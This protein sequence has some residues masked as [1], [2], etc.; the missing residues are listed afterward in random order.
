VISHRKDVP[1]SGSIQGVYYAFKRVF[2]DNDRNYGSLVLISTEKR[3][4]IM[5]CILRASGKNFDVDKFLSQT[6]L[7]P[8]AVF[9][10]GKPK[11]QARPKGKKNEFSGINIEVS[12]ADFNQLDQ[13]IQDAIKFLQK[14]KDEVRNLIDFLGLDSESEIDFAI[15][16]RNVRAQTDYFPP[17]LLVLAGT[18]GL[19]IRLSIYPCDEGR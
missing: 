11:Y 1:G 8:C 6:K 15:E 12:N 17:K 7:Q 18:L 14:N 5:S 10:K 2:W 13:Q 19:G 16:K 4:T 9:K 3:K